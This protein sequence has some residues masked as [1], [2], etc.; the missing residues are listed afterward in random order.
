MCGWV[1]RGIWGTFCMNDIFN[2]VSG[3]Q[4]EGKQCRIVVTH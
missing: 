4:S 2:F 1:G 3:K